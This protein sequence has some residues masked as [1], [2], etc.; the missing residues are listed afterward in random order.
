M[1]KFIDLGGVMLMSAFLSVG[2]LYGLWAPDIEL[3]ELR[4]RYGA[5]SQ[6]VVMVDGLNVQYKD[7]GPQDAPVVLLL[8][9]FGSSLQTW[10]LWATQLEKQ[11]RVIRLD[12]PGFGLTG[13][14][15]L[16][17]YSE[18]GDLATLTHFVDKLGLASFSVV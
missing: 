11:Y 9:G 13:P 17:D 12:L 2:L 5:S 10:D 14:S 8:H 16:H 6:H 7:T 15:P 4:T 3:S 18:R 1:A